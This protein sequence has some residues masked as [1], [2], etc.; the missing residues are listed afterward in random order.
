MDL[1]DTNAVN[2]NRNVDKKNLDNLFENHQT[3]YDNCLNE[4]DDVKNNMKARLD[5]AKALNNCSNNTGIAD[6]FRS[7]NAKSSII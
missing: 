6:K 3:V 1:A 5:A 7:A 2:I 4:S